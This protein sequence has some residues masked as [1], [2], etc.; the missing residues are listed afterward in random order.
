MDAREAR[1]RA[2]KLREEIN[3]LR[4]RYHVLDDPRVTD[5]IYDSLTAELREIEKEH[6]QLLTPD[7]PTGRIGGKALEKFEK[8]RHQVRMLS[9]N[10]AFSEEEMKDWEERIQRLVPGKSR[11][12]FAELKFDGLATS[13]V[14]ENGVLLQGA[15]R[16][17]GFIGEN[18]TQNLKTIR[19]IPLR[20]NLELKHT[21]Q[22]SSDLK[23]RVVAKLAKTQRIEVRGEALMSK[24]AFA[25]LN[26]H[27]KKLKEAEFANPRNAAAG[28][29]RQLDP[30]I[31]ASRKLSWHAY[32][33]ITDLG[34]EAHEEEH[35]I[36]AML[37]FPVDRH[38]EVFDNLEEIFEFWR[39]IEKMRE[40]LTFEIDGIVVQVNQREIFGKLG[41][42][43]KA[44]RGA[45]AFKFSAKKATTVVED[46]T[47]QVG[48]QGNL[49][50]VAHLRPVKVGGVTISRASLHNEDEIKRLGLKIGDTVVVQ[51]AG[52]VIPQVIEVLPRL[53]T[54][55]EKEFH[56]PRHCPACGGKVERRSLSPSSPGDHFD[57][58]Q[59]RSER[60]RM[61]EGRNKRRGR[62]NVVEQ[63]S[64]AHLCMNPSC[65][66]KNLRAIEHLV[67]AFEIYTIGP[68]IIERFKDEGLITDAADI[69]KLKKEDIAGLERFGE[70][71]AENIINS[72]E[73]HKTIS[74]AKF[75]Y[76]LGI[77]HVGEETAIDLAEHF[78]SLEKLRTASFEEIDQIPNVG[79]AMAQSIYKY[80]QDE[81][82]LKFI[83]R[84]LDSVVRIKNQESRIK[85]GPLA[86]K[87]IVVTG[88]LKSL[89]RDEAKDA[90]RKAGG[91]W[92][93]S[94][95]KNTDYVVVGENPGS[96]FEKAKKLGVKILEEKEFLRVI[97]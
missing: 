17:D 71:S 6:P 92:V 80:F 64:V 23:K 40:K 63:Y 13:L 12:Y 51:R 4:Y 18:I 49:T 57:S 38:H 74:L 69:F 60:S 10:D 73:E 22:I 47:V 9:L 68:K 93:S 66:A 89:S 95:S 7:S 39:K 50:P 53:R 34:Q 29:V 3:D 20:L 48:R 94:V 37:G 59:G 16:G 81:R 96:K 52:D 79:S 41:I 76:A 25:E 85:N 31:T 83:Q 90:V 61:S 45:I 91:D 14:Y 15:T 77:L 5:E 26:L 2:T 56:L 58:T 75:I 46:I 55:K 86:G 32:Q 72:I 88:T 43:G 44:P 1:L 19:A 97:K 30:K 35:L 42:V 11:H 67:N 36:C 78:G 87:K 24:Q 65:P 70:K 21:T 62:M 8:V 82:N 33:L 84:L 54:G 27:Q 28:S